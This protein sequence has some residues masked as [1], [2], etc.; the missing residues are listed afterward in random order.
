ML[1]AFA[2]GIPVLG[3]P[4]GIAPE[5]LK[6][7]GG[8]LLPLNA[9]DFVFAAS[10]EVEKMKADSNYYRKLCDESYEIGKSIDWSNIREEWIN[11]INNI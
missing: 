2:A 9:D 6:H 3:T 1:E 5:Y 10:Y 7:G 11:Y 4:T 8:K